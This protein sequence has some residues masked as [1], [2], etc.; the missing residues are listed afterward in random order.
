MYICEEMDAKY[1]LA[2][3]FEA[4]ML[5]K[6]ALTTDAVNNNSFDFC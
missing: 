3:E 1:A 6:A 4:L 5:V 2:D